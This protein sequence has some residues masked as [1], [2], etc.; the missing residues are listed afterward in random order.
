MYIET[1]MTGVDPNNK[2]IVVNPYTKGGKQGNQCI[3]SHFLSSLGAHEKTD[4]TSML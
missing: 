1:E 2:K 4:C 3:L